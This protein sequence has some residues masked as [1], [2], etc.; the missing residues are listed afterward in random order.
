MHKNE[1]KLWQQVLRP[2]LHAP[3]KGRVATRVESP[4]TPGIPDVLFIDQGHVTWYELKYLDGLPVRTRR[5]HWGARVA[6]RA[7]MREWVEDGNGVA[8]FLIGVGAE[9][10][11][12]RYDTPCPCT[13][14]QFHEH[15]LTGA[16]FD[17]D[18][19]ATLREAHRR[20][21]VE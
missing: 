14:E 5:I 8:F 3:K 1:R 13:I 7:F 21:T 10:I 15:A 18:L 2:A 6:Q 16:A 9:L 20:F 17:G 12:L 11:V 4:D 19:L